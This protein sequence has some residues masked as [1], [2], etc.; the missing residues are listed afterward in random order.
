MA[1]AGFG[2]LI[3][4]LSGSIFIGMS[5]FR[6]I[7]IGIGWGDLGFKIRIY[8][9]PLMINTEPINILSRCCSVRCLLSK[10]LIIPSL[11]IVANVNG[12]HFS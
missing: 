12:Y 5:R 10:I 4:W 8:I 11:R 9:T 1:L 3:F 2:P 6:I 7:M